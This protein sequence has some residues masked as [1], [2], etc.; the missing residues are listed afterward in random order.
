MR[1]S[2]VAFFVLV[3]CGRNPD[4]TLPVFAGGAPIDSSAVHSMTIDARGGVTVDGVACADEREVEATLGLVVAAMHVDPADV[5]RSG[6]QCVSDPLLVRIDRRTI[7][8]EAARRLAYTSTRGH[9]IDHDDIYRKWIAVRDAR[10]GEERCVRIDHLPIHGVFVEPLLS[11]TERKWDPT[12]TFLIWARDDPWPADRGDTDS[13]WHVMYWPDA[14]HVDE[15]NV[16]GWAAV[17]ELIARTPEPQ[18][19]FVVEGSIRGD[20]PWSDVLPLIGDAL[21]LSHGR[22]EI[23]FRRMPPRQQR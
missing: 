14:V 11:E 4:V 18:R 12:V 19:D 21:E 13:T 6:R 7:W 3:A 2:L 16:S 22:L 5:A 9:S 8:V 15:S 10:S 1:S 23:G 20:L 17:H